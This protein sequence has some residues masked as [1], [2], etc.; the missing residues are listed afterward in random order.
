MKDYLERP[1]KFAPKCVSCHCCGYNY[2]AP[3]DPPEAT[4]GKWCQAL[5]FFTPEGEPEAMKRGAECPHWIH[6]KLC[7][8]ECAPK[9]M[10]GDRWYEKD[11]MA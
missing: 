8:S 10:P 9:E 5:S 2:P 3:S 6:A 4:H 1:L 11:S 7:R